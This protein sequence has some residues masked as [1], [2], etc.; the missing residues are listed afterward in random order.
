[1]LHEANQLGAARV[2]VVETC[3]GQR[4]GAFERL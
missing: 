1:M 2:E 3:Q 4:D